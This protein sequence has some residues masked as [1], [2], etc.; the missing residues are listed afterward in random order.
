METLNL[1]AIQ[2]LLI[3]SWFS[4]RQENAY[5]LQYLLVGLPDNFLKKGIPSCAGEIGSLVPQSQKD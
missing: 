4:V 1:D 3:V 2:I 5:S